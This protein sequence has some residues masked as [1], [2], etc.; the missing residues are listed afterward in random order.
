VSVAHGTRF[1]SWI[2][3]AKARTLDFVPLDGRLC[4]TPENPAWWIYVEQAQRSLKTKGYVPSKAWM[5][6]GD[7]ADYVFALHRLREA[8]A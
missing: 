4:A 6:S 8:R 1:G 3:D 5:D 2:Y 7:I